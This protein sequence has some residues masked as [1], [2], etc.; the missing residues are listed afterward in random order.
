MKPKIKQ[1]KKFAVGVIGVGFMGENHVR[2]VQA[3]PGVRLA[4]IMDEDPLRADVVSTKYNTT[5]YGDCASL[6]TE[7]NAVIIAT[8]TSTHFDLAMQ[9][10]EARKHV[11]IEKPL[12]STPEDGELLVEKAREKGVVLSCGFI[13]RFNP[14]FTVAESLLRKDKPLIVN[15][16]RESPLPQRITD[17]SVV[18]DM[19]IHDLDLAL[20]IADAPTQEFKAEGKKVKTKLLDQA[21]VNLFFK[22]G[23]IANI[24]ASRVSQSKERTLSVNCEHSSIKADLLGKTVRQK[25][26]PDPKAPTIEPPKEVEHPVSDADQITLELKDFFFA[27]KRGKEPAV[28]GRDAL[29]ALKLAESIERSILKK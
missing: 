20:R 29:A 23:I 18:F 12:A 15:I 24:E 19:M 3:L 9:A 2:I 7:V 4:G 13:E 17:A 22:N 21:F 8:P 28:T 26:L 1:N 10:I 25:F 14:A 27:A 11:F 16:K 5:A 6:F